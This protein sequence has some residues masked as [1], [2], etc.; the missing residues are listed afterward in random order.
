[1]KKNGQPRRT[2]VPHIPYRPAAGA[3]PGV[4]VMDFARLVERARGHGV[5][6]YAPRRPE[7]HEFIA[8]HAG[9]VR[10]S[11]DFLEHRVPAGGWFWMRP[12]QIHR[13]ISDLTETEGTV[14]VF[15]PEFLDAA[16]RD[17]VGLDRRVPQRPVTPEGTQKGALDS[18]LSLLRTEHERLAELPLEAHIDVMRHLLAVIL[19]RL[20]HLNG[21]P[22]DR[23][24]GHEVFLRFQEAVD[25]DLATSHRVA[26]YAARLGYSVRTLTRATRAAAGCGAKRFIDDQILLEAKR[27]LSHTDLPPSGIGERLGFAYST[28]F[29]AF[30]Q[31]RT[32]MT[33]TAFRAAARGTAP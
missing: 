27:L 25:Q 9:A 19:L 33:P 13:Y 30:F 10:C 4:E 1:M 3:P 2:E 11:A 14:V 8:V 21:G 18:T 28:A 32:G 31:Q 15:A 16:T 6:I 12:G 26:D 22:G 23:A 5:D 24:A 17:A 7:F 20:T 29:S